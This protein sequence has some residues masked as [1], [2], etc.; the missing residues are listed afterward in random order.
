MA[1]QRITDMTLE[2]L[3]QLI[4][5][6]IKHIVSAQK[7]TRTM[8]EVNASIRRNRIVPPAGAKSAL[9]MVREDRDA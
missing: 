7:D 6:R 4:D 3:T 1:A 9:E 8:A 2:Q 5:Q